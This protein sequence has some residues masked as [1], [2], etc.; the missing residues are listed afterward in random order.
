MALREARRFRSQQSSRLRPADEAVWR[1]P[2]VRGTLRP[3]KS[4]S[5]QRSGAL[6]ATRTTAYQRVICG[7]QHLTMRINM[8]RFTRL[9]S[10]FSKKSRTTP[11]RLRFIRCITI[12]SA[13]TKYSRLRP[14]RPLAERKTLGNVHI[15]YQ[16]PP[17]T[18]GRQPASQELTTGGNAQTDPLPPLDS[19]NKK[20][21]MFF[22]CSH[23][24]RRVC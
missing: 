6:K 22:L 18:F 17:R 11:P 13:F 3:A 21:T 2:A 19:R 14:Q 8:R 1:G 4:A 16:V 7:A 12:S 23:I 10:A 24:R 9:T 20:G 5:G 15:A